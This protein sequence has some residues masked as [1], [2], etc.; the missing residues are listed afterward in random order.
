MA[1]LFLSHSSKDKSFVK[2]LAKDLLATGHEVWLDE[3]EIRVGECIVKKVEEGIENSD[4][5]IIVLSNHSVSSTWV[6]KEWRSKYME[7]IV[8]N[9][10]RILPVIIED[11]VVPPL[12][13]SK[14]Y[15]DFRRSYSQGIS[16]LIDSLASDPNLATSVKRKGNDKKQLLRNLLL[17]TQS[18]KDRL[19]N[20]ISECLIIAKDINDQELERFCSVELSGLKN[21]VQYPDFLH[22]KIDVY[23]S[24]NK[25]DTTWPGWDGDLSRALDMMD[26][27]PDKYWKIKHF[28]WYSVFEIEELAEIQNANKKI[29]TYRKK[30][31]EINSEISNPDLNLYF[32]AKADTLK[33]LLNSIR[34]KLT[35]LLIQRI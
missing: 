24:T 31:A 22:R 9:E 19:S 12:L 29:F 10:V 16:E 30:A 20:N 7:E 17:K 6:G 11:C 25:L 26:N 33:N 23:V 18:N 34:I 27:N 8:E 21:G 28:F 13:S 1:N 5:V 4:Y 32:Y 15:A 14:K 2:T 3:W 35:E